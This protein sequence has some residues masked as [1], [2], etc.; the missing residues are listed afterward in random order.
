MVDIIQL[1][2]KLYL[3]YKVMVETSELCF[4]GITP[5]NCRVGGKCSLKY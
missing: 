3:N 1:I 4:A 2:G 5:Q